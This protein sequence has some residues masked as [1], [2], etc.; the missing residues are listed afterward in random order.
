MC[1]CVSERAR[2]KPP[3]VNRLGDGTV[4]GWM[5]GTQNV[6]NGRGKFAHALLS[7]RLDGG[8]GGACDGGWSREA[9]MGIG[10]IRPFGLWCG[11]C[12]SSMCRLNASEYWWSV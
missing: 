10:W 12:I 11:L 7:G 8:L 5:D 4:D 1:V 6:R 3:G 2:V 9:L